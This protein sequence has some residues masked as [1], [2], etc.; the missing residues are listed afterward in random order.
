MRLAKN[1]LQHTHL[2]EF[3]FDA[4]KAV[5]KV[6]E[7]VVT[8]GANGI[9][10]NSHIDDVIAVFKDKSYCEDFRLHLKM[11]EMDKIKGNTID[12]ELMLTELESKYT[13]LVK[14]NEWSAS[15]PAS[16][17]DSKYM[18]MTAQTPV[19]SK[20]MDKDTL[21]KV[22]LASLQQK[23]NRGRRGKWI[24]LHAIPPPKEGEPKTKI[25]HNKTVYFCDYCAKW[26]MNPTHTTEGCK[27]KK[28][29]DGK[30]TL[31]ANIASL[32]SNFDEE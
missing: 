14:Q 30:A 10:S 32:L 15:T 31:Q 17:I 11:F 1:E 7:L 24:P 22:L 20:S 9:L 25:E 6:R 4:S 12:I 23:P 18:A 21:L 29:N 16:K 2:K 26:S 13:N 8:L 19:A 5:K 27:K 28:A 3:N